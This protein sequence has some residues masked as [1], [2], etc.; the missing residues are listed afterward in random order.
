M[1]KILAINNNE[2]KRV[3]KIDMGD[4]RIVKLKPRGR[5]LSE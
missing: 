2:V 3:H 5:F 1:N 4:M